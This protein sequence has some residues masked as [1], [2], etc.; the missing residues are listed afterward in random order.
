[1]V[2]QIPQIF[3]WNIKKLWQNMYNNYVE[4]NKKLYVKLINSTLF[5]NEKKESE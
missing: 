2:A 4:K 1:M 3:K 5:T